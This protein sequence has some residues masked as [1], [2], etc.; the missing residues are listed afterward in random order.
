MATGI[1]SLTMAEIHRAETIAGK[2]IQQLADN[3][4]PNA[5]LMTAVAFVV[6]QRTETGL[7]FEKFEETA[8]LDEV[9]AVIG[10]GDEDQKK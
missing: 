3:K 9:M 2:S 4:S 7:V 8:T 5:R 6:K 10:G 1:E